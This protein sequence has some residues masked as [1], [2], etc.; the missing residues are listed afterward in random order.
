MALK[1]KLNPMGALGVKYYTLTVVTSPANATCVLTVNGIQYTTK[2]LKVKKGTVVNYSVSYT[3]TTTKTGSITMDSD[4]TLT[5][6][7]TYYTS[8]T[9]QSWSQPT[10]SANGTIGGSSFAVD[11]SGNW[12]T[13]YNQFWKGMDG[14]S[15]T[16]V[17]GYP[18]KSPQPSYIF[19]NPNPLKVS[20]LHFKSYAGGDGAGW[21]TKAG[22]IYVSTNGNTWTNLKDFTNS[23]TGAGAEYDVSVLTASG[24]KYY[25]ITLTQGS[26][27]GA[28]WAE[29]TITATEAIESYT[30]YFNLVIT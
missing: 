2:S 13:T 20:N 9:Y 12:S 18:N 24:F 6:T 14:N 30:Y 16:I 3:D 5:F 8:T 25:K 11:G 22:T 23:V 19:Y 29:M 10:L 4:K 27:Y 17:L 28:G 15:S 7:R 21:V 1:T 26:S